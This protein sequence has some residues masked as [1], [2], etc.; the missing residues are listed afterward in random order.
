[1]LLKLGPIDLRCV[2]VGVSGKDT[3]LW[4]RAL[5]TTEPVKDN[6]LGMLNLCMLTVGLIVLFV[7]LYIHAQNMFLKPIQLLYLL[8]D[9]WSVS[10][11]PMSGTTSTSITHERA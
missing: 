9:V 3:R 1:V 2:P 8:L 10:L 6:M 11:A 7:N 5:L 4:K